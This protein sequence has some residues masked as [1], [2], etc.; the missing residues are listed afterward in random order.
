MFRDYVWDCRRWMFPAKRFNWLVKLGIDR[1]SAS[2]HFHL[3]N[4]SRIRNIVFSAIPRLYE[5]RQVSC[6]IYVFGDLKIISVVRL[7]RYRF[8]MEGIYWP[9][10]S[11]RRS[12]SLRKENWRFIKPYN[13]INSMFFNFWLNPWH[14][15]RGPF[16]LHNFDL[17]VYL[18]RG[19]HDPE[20]DFF[21]K[22]INYN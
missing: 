7:F 5:P 13:G 19:N 8:L 12:L 21:I 3:G 10:F 22:V 4:C 2:G 9:S 15:P 18:V 11:Q 16:C 6:I 14:I 20:L 1:H 17:P